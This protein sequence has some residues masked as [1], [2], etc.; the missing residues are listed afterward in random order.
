MLIPTVI[1]PIARRVEDCA[2]FM[3][4]TQVPELW[5]GDLN[6]PRIPFT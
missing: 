5:E 3:K 6:L 1:G 4:A 2:L